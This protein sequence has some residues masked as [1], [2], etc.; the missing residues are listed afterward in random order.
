VVSRYTPRERAPGTHWTGGWVGPR[1]V[2]DALCVYVYMYVVLH[3]QLSLLFIY[4]RCKFAVLIHTV[5]ITFHANIFMFSFIT[6]SPYR[7]SVT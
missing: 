4:C 2:L 5:D 1:A 7:K 3:V 6:Y